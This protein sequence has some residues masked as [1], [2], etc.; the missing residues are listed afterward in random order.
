MLCIF[1][2]EAQHFAQVSLLSCCQV[3]ARAQVHS[4][5]PC[6]IYGR[7]SSTETGFSPSAFAFPISIIPPVLHF[8]I[9]FIH[10]QNCINKTVAF[11]LW[12]VEDQQGFC[13]HISFV[14]KFVYILL[15]TFNCI[16]FFIFS[17]SL[18]I[19]CTGFIFSDHQC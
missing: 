4:H 2:Q 11:N 13:K 5:S 8:H 19:M 17:P 7:H 16:F 1:H 18:C 6:E 9:S 14:M 12:S 3:T 15:I 10:H